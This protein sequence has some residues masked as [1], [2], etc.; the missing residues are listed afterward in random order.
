MLYHSPSDLLKDVLGKIPIS[1]YIAG[2]LTSQDYR[3]VCS[4]LQ[5][6]EIL[7]S[8]L[9]ETFHVYFRREG[10][11]HKVKALIADSSETSTTGS[12][13]TT[14]SKPSAVL[15]GSK[16]REVTGSSGKKSVSPQGVSSSAHDMTEVSSSA[17]TSK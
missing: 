9:S 10:V 6:A 16:H 15:E 8:K 12:P 3:I 11:M 7:M 4:A 5:K 13:Q 14:T 17:S 2:M 1:S